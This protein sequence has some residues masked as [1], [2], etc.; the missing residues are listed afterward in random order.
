MLACRTFAA[1]DQI[2]FAD[3]SGDH[4]PMHLDA[5]LARRT[6]AGVQVVHGVHLLLWSLD[7]LAREELGRSPVLRLKTNFKRFVPINETVSLTLA[8]RTEA[9]VQL[10][11]VVTG[12][13]VAQIS[14]EFG[15]PV[16]TS[17]PLLGDPDSAPE[18]PCELTLEQMEGL[19]GTLAF[20]S[21]PKD[22]VAMFPAASAWLGP[23]RIAAL[24]A[25][26]LLVG[27]VCPGLHS[28]YGDLTVE[29]CHEKDAKD[30]L[31]FRVVSTDPRFRLVRLAIEGGGLVGSIKA[32]A[33]TPPAPQAPSSEL[34]HAVEPG[35]FAGSTA[36][37]IG[38][39]RG[40]GEVTAK[41]LAAG[42]ARVLITYRVGRAE[43]EEVARDIRATG[44]MCET[45]AYDAGQPPD[46]QLI[47][48]SGAPTHAYYF[49][50]PLIFRAQSALFARAR[51][52]AFLDVY[53]DGFLHLAL[54]LR[55]RRSDV[56]LLYPSSEYVVERP[57]GMLEYAMAKAAGE[58]L[59]SEMNLAWAPLHVTVARLPRLPTD[60]TASVVEA[61]LP[62]PVV[63]LLPAVREA[64]SWPRGAKKVISHQR[65]TDHGRAEPS[66]LV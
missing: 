28:I 65:T 49:A 40:L 26:S 24:A 43:A 12:L 36:L 18:A 27:M 66:K 14:V 45:L 47:T 25:T 54:A 51:L 53:V 33:R 48:L 38:G 21:A 16:R 13:T 31:G 59:C 61:E 10:D 46:A 6:Q 41:L 19:A 60:Q 64:Q 4:N 37:V 50:T 42:G 52:D 11:F 39:S 32:V 44:G 56:S 55:V 3:V 63:S 35:E 58:T 20:A 7:V 57:R 15:S 29:F 34:A 2:R 62:S 23:R 30:R 8:K 22:T 5:V 17:E 1:A 9:C